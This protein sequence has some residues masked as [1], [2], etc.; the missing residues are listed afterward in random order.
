MVK[1]NY[2][3][4]HTSKPFNDP[5][6]LLCSVGRTSILM[7]G[8]MRGLP[9]VLF[10]DQSWQWDKRRNGGSQLDA[11]ECYNGQRGGYI[12]ICPAEVGPDD[13]WSSALTR[14]IIAWRKCLEH[15]AKNG[16]LYRCKIWNVYLPCLNIWMEARFCFSFTFIVDIATIIL[17]QWKILFTNRMI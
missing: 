12:H 1:Q 17:L 15:I 8:W 6:P 10:M 14:L 9:G 16:G 4:V 11:I 5:R 2:L 13:K 7:Q 3:F